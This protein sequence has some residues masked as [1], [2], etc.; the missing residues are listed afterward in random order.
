MALQQPAAATVLGVVRVVGRVQ[1]TGVRY[2][3]P[4]SSDRSIS[5]IRRETSLLPLSPGAPRWRRPDGP[6]RW[7]TMASRVSS[8]TVIPSR[9]ASWRRRASRSSGSLTVVRFTVCQHI[10]A[11]SDLTAVRA[12][13]GGRRRT[14][15]PFRPAVLYWGEPRRTSANVRS[16]NCKTAAES[17]GGSTNVVIRHGTPGRSAVVRPLDWSTAAETRRRTPRAVRR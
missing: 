13:L 14:D 8:D 11:D 1:R 10:I 17:C 9:S 4:A 15:D 7:V 3:R 2:Q 5:S 12:N 6:T 16:T